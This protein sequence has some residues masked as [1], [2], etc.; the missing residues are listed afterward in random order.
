MGAGARC[1]ADP[2]AAPARPRRRDPAHL[3]LGHH[4]RA[5]GRDAL[6]Q[7]HH[8]QHRALRAAPGPGRRRRGAHGLAHGAPDRLHVRAH[9]AHR[10]AGLGGAAGHLGAEAGH[11]VDQRRGRELHHG[12]HTLPLRPVE[13]RGRV[14]HGRAHAA[15]LSVRRRAHSGRAGRAGAPGAGRQDR[16]GLGHDR[17]RRRHAHAAGR[18]RRALHPHRRLP[19]ARRRAQGGRC[20]RP[21][22]A[23]GRDRQAAAARLLQLRRLPEAPAAQRHRRGR[24]VRHRRP[25]AHRR[26]RLRAH[27]RAHQGRDHSRR[28]EHS[29]G[30]DRV[31][32]VP[33][34][35]RGHGR[36]GRLPRRAPGRARLRGGGAQAGAAARPAVDR[37]LPQGREGGA[38]V[39][40]GA[41]RGARDDAVHALRK[42]PEIQAARPA[43]RGRI[44]RPG[45]LS[46]PADPFDTT[47][48]T[49]YATEAIRRR[50]GPAAGPRRGRTGWPRARRPCGLGPGACN[51]TRW[52]MAV[53]A[54]PRGRRLCARRQHR[55]D[56]AHPRAVA[57]G[58]ARPDRADRQQARRQRQHLGRRSGARRARRPH[59]PHRAD[60][61]RDRQPL[62]LQGEPAAFARP[63]A[64]GHGRA[65]ADVPRRQAAA[66]REGHARTG[67]AGANQARHA[68]VRLGRRGHAAAPGLRAVQA[69]HRHA[70]D[71]RALPRRGACAAGRALGP[72]R[73]RLRPRHRLPAHPRRQGQAAGHRER[74]AL[75][76]L[77][78]GAHGGRAGLPGRQPRHL[79]RHVGAQRHA[80]RGAGPHERR[81]RQGAGAARRQVALRRPG[82]RARGHEH[83]RVPQAAGRRRRHAVLADC[84]PED[85]GGLSS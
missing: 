48:E 38:A 65:H 9:D 52:R 69:G 34:P 4:R 61:G 35:R 30:R 13:D 63:H 2:A 68:L 23:G 49:S 12:V 82:C 51:H 41:P 25:R 44:G 22:V 33:P 10:V 73:F 84:A 18:R 26:A 8:G 57:V 19:A 60:F 83:A 7:H 42:D 1:R 64:G 79:V 5:Q 24:L 11:R 66:A 46:A 40:P 53:Q 37:C 29:R 76:L 72:G 58:V 39:H 16:V 32:A 27:R 43:A 36:R 62:A 75:A 54:H 15:R 6:G 70:G 45:R 81:T 20:R 59:L 78:R 71:A 31:A 28:R 85:R 80:A 14:G 50:R 77:P 47:T 3:H 21:G 55:R 74:Q 56:G 17:E 67:H